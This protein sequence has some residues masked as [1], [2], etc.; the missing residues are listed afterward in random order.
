MVLARAKKFGSSSKKTPQGQL[1]LELF[2][3][4]EK[5]SNSFNRCW[6]IGC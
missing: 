3:E 4:A 5:E 1:S 6:H 2:D